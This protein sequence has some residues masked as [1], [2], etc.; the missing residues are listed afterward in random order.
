MILR[1]LLKN[2]SRIADRYWLS[3]FSLA[4]IFQFLN[5]NH[6]VTTYSPST[7][8]SVRVWV[9][10]TPARIFDFLGRESSLVSLLIATSS[11]Y[12][13]SSKFR[14]LGAH[15]GGISNYRHYSSVILSILVIYHWS[16][17]SD[18]NDIWQNMLRL[19]QCHRD[20]I[21]L[22]LTICIFLH[23]NTNL[24]LDHGFRG[25]CGGYLT[26]DQAPGKFFLQTSKTLI[27]LN[28]IHITQILQIRIL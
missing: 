2:I 17:L 14:L 27:F 18:Q 3:S 6:T 22:C 9:H 12:F 24:T 10:K 28:K 20:K 19:Y 16:L 5:L 15:R 13:T 26:T 21:L 7:S 1:I 25:I 4:L 23:K 11:R 8:V